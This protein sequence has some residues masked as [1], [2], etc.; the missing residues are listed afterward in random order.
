[1]S[2]QLPAWPVSGGG[3]PGPNR[4]SFR[5]SEEPAPITCSTNWFQIHLFHELED[6]GHTGRS[7]REGR[8]KLWGLGSEGGEEG[9]D[10][11]D[12]GKKLEAGQG[13]V[14]VDLER[15]HHFKEDCS[16]L[17]IQAFHEALGA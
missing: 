13:E 6:E 4:S 11:E 5:S 15:H 7:A 17:Q 8:W 14:G 2:F 3:Q 1:M 16:S 10:H 12:R 9:R